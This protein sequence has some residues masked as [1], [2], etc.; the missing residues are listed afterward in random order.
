MVLSFAFWG[1]RTVEVI[2]EEEVFSELWS[3][4][5]KV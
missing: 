3:V 5:L 4:G 2:L 1:E